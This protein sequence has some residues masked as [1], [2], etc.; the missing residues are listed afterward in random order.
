MIDK[1]KRKQ[2]YEVIKRMNPKQGKSIRYNYY[3]SLA[4]WM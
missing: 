1:S 4:K 2:I 3:P